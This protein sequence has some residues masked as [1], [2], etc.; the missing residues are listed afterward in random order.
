MFL[1]RPTDYP[2]TNARS[3]KDNLDM[4]GNQR[5]RPPKPPGKENVEANVLHQHPQKGNP[6]APVRKESQ[7]RK[8][9]YLYNSFDKASE[10]GSTVFSQM[11]E[12]FMTS[13]AQIPSVSREITFAQD[14]NLK[15]KKPSNGDSNSVAASPLTM[16]ALAAHNQ[17]HNKSQDPLSRSWAAG[18]KETSQGNNTLL[19]H[20]DPEASKIAALKQDRSI[21]ESHKATRVQQWTSQVGSRETRQANPQEL[22]SLPSSA[23]FGQETNKVPSFYAPMQQDHVGSLFSFEKESLAIAAN[24]SSSTNKQPPEIGSKLNFENDQGISG[25][26]QTTSKDESI[27]IGS[28]NR[29]SSKSDKNGS[30]E[31]GSLIRS[32][33]DNNNKSL[34]KTDM[35]VMSTNSEE[36]K[37]IETGY[38]NQ[39]S[40]NSKNSHLEHKVSDNFTDLDQISLSDLDGGESVK[41][42]DLR[43]GVERG[44]NRTPTRI[45]SRPSLSSSP[46]K[47]DGGAGLGTMTPSQT[48]SVS[49]VTTNQLDYFQGTELDLSLS[50]IPEDGSSTITGMTGV[51]ITSTALAANDHRFRQGVNALDEKIVKV[52]ESLEVWKKTFS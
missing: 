32:Q 6:T 31:T 44:G 30:L 51:S 24:K 27:E 2:M 26:N 9:D 20:S 48:L 5:N 18:D 47:E 23:S 38:L 25:G 13:G 1:S 12:T 49:S 52:K 8:W 42:I 34:D 35:N 45:L 10:S 50:T 40:S 36:D 37:S 21:T 19:Y 22:G 33:E 43:E 29:A 17:F 7:D 28:L 14:Q 41:P 15:G 39:G 16:A 46:I 4:T 3:G 11:K